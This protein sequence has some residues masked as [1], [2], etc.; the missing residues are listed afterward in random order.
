MVS[1][2]Q[3]RRQ[4]RQLQHRENQNVETKPAEDDEA[5]D[6]KQREKVNQDRRFKYMAS[7]RQKIAKSNY[8]QAHK[9]AIKER[10]RHSYA[11]NRIPILQKS[12]LTYNKKPFTK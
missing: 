1:K 2:T 9:T 11:T 10:M 12:R 5:D 7:T 3:K 6:Q 4:R 8:Y